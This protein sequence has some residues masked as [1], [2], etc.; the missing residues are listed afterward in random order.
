MGYTHYWNNNKISD[1]KWKNFIADVKKVKAILPNNIELAYEYDCPDRKP[2]I[3][4][5]Q[6]RFNGI[7]DDGHETF[8][9]EKKG[10]RDG[11]AFCKTARKPYDLMVCAV[12]ILFSHHIGAKSAS[13]SSDGDIK[14]EEWAEAFALVEKATGIQKTNLK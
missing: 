13:V 2:V 7:G 4:G 6:V 11:F 8:L 5:K 9:I 1:K 14:G 10:V 3:D 12:L